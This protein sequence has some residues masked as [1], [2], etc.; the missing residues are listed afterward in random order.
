MILNNTQEFIFDISRPGRTAYDLPDSDVPAYDLASELPAYLNREREADFPEVSELQLVRHY[1]ALSNRN[2]GVESGP[3][4]LGSC[5]MKYNPKVNEVIAAFDGFN[6]IHPLQAASSSQGA[7]QLL[8]E[9]KQY[10][11]EVSGMDAMTLQPA[12]GAQGELTAI[13]VFKAYHEA[14]G[15]GEK[16][17][18]I[19]IP[20]SAHGTNPA[21]AMVAGYDVL[22]IPSNP[23]GTVDIEALKEAVG[24][25]TAGI[26]LTN[27]NT[28]GLYEKDI[29]KIAD[30]VH[31]A[32]GLLYYD[33]ANSNAIMGIS[34]PG[35][36]GF[37]A[38]HFNLHKT[39]SG[40]H[41]GGGPGSGPIGVKKFLEPFLP[42][43]RIEKEGDRYVIKDDFPQSIG[44]MKGAFG[45][46]GVNVR[47]YAYIRAMG[48]DGLKQASQDA[49]LNANYVKARIA[50]YYDEPFEAFHCKHE[51]VAAATRQR[52]QGANAKDI[53]K[54]LMDYGIHAPTTYFPLIVPECLMI[55]PTETESKEDLDYLADVLIQIAKEVEEN[56]ELVASAPHKTPVKRLDEVG[57]S[58]NPILIY[59]KEAKE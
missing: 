24:D 1:T 45:N 20:D 10:L 12:A 5:T 53:G 51:F 52:D 13:L 57:A 59:Q 36:M 56:P 35:A 15:D 19:I 27:P 8:Y 16:R 54:R 2:F 26:M 50:K 14:N 25:D 23:E 49:V 46:F 18:K 48:P 29:L 22:E 9:L 37:D 47:A 44:R 58:K 3:Y 17:T 6:H 32:G 42:E 41:G 38:V 11:A 28:I 30:I 34:S 40:P 33:G 39:F 31:K 55:E 7:L 4:P 43:P 21:T